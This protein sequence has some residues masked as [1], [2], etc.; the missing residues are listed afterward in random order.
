M[1]FLYNKFA[2]KL[3]LALITFWSLVT[4]YYVNSGSWSLLVLMTLAALL[5]LLFIW[6]EIASIA[7]LIYLSFIV[8]YSFFVLLFQIGLPVWLVMLGVLIIFGYLFTYAEQKIGILGNK[9][10]IYLLLFSILTLEVF[11]ILTY[12]MISP[13]NQSLVIATLSYLFIGFCYTVLAKHT[14][15]KFSTYVTSSAI[16]IMLI[17]L[18]A[19]WVGV[20]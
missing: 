15:N 12:F 9:R 1:A 8:A 6:Y 2:R 17:L 7:I 13:I 11:L 19:N 16:I 20:V 5:T 3:I 18:T 14:D 4:F 10:L